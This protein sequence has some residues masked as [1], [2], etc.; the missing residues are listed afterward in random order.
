MKIDTISIFNYWSIKKLLETFLDCKLKIGGNSC[1][2]VFSTIDT[3]K[4]S[5]TF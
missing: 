3:K 4:D 1:L 5:D 2:P